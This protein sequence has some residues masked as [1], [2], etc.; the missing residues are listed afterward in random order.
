MKVG[1]KEYWFNMVRHKEV[2]MLQS[3]CGGEGRAT[4]ET[5]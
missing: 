2:I 3:A 1:T 5:N 4:E